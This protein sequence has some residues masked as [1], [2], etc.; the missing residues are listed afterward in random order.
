MSRLD[1]P[2]EKLGNELFEPQ[3]LSSPAYILGINYDGEIGSA[4]LKLYEPNSHRLFRWT[5]RTNHRPY[6]I[7]KKK[8][9]KYDTIRYLNQNIGGK[10][11]DLQFEKRFDALQDKD[12]DVVRIVTATPTD[13]AGRQD[14]IR[15]FI[16]VNEADI[17]YSDCYVWDTRIEPGMPYKIVNGDLISCVGDNVVLPDLLQK[18]ITETVTE[19]TLKRFFRML[20]APVPSY[21]RIAVDIEVFHPSENSMPTPYESEFQIIACSL[22]SNDN[23]NKV[24][25]LRRNNYKPE[26]FKTEKC[27]VEF[28]DTEEAL[29]A[30]IFEYLWDYEIVLTFNGDEFDMRYLYNRAVRLGFDRSQIPIQYHQSWMGLKYGIHID[31]MRFFANMSI[32]VYAFGAKYKLS[33]R[34]V[35]LDEVGKGLVNQGKVEH[36]MSIGKM[37]YAQ[38]A[39]YGFGDAELT[40]KLTT[41]GNNTTMNLLTA[42]SRISYQSIEDVCRGGASTWIK[43]LMFR[44]HRVRNWV[45]PR[46]ERDEENPNEEL[47]G[48]IIGGDILSVKNVISTKSETEG[49]KFRGAM[50]VEPVVGL[51]FGVSVLDFASLYPSIIETWNLG[52]ETVRCFHK[53]C[54]TVNPRIVPFTTHWVC[55]KERAMTAEIIGSLKDIRVQWYKPKGKTNDY[56]QTVEQT[57]KVFMNATYG[58]FAS[59]KFPLYC[60][61]MGESV[62][63]VGRYSISQVI[64]EARRR[65]ISVFYGDTDSVFMEITKEQLESLKEYAHEKLNMQMDLDKSYVWLALSGRKKNYL[66]LKVEK[67][68]LKIDKKGLTGKKRH[69]PAWIKYVFDEVLKILKMMEKPEHLEPARKAI[70][71]F[72]QAELKE[73]RGRKVPIS[74]L[75]FTMGLQKDPADYKKNTPIHVKVARQMEGSKAGDVIHFVKVLGPAGARHISVTRPEEINI[76]AYEEFLKNTLIQIFDCLG[77]EWKDVGGDDSQTTLF[78]ESLKSKPTALRSRGRKKI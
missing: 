56:Y 46:C 41:F 45:I 58:V 59:D 39:E 21:R 35:G 73:L 14:S 72:V 77:M 24:L 42:L 15:N 1:D 65:G 30:K 12:I 27:E 61:P 18:S 40:L 19:A 64:E 37:T 57:I 63:Q 16:D 50:V 47:R 68:G 54:E 2:K 33:G 66:G 26:N 5:D 69:T 62:T 22:S 32:Q 52:Y 49:K 44:E 53:D 25:L 55:K 36:A 31:L 48:R 4:Y 76:S 29:I 28:Y 51:H 60:P 17:R 13:V 70:T 8:M 43:S 74:A 6:C 71:Y 11:I 67:D 38:L 10:F 20:E 23:V 78:G 75:A 7:F 9:D 34:T 3:S